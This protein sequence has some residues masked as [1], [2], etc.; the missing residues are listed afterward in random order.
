MSSSQT[1]T[2]Q[3]VTKGSSLQ[4]AD[5]ARISKQSLPKPPVFDDKYEEREYLKG[6]LAATFRLFAK[7]GFDDGV[8][9]HVTLRDPVDPDTFWVN[10]LGVPFA[11]L[12][13]SDLV[14]LDHDGVI[15][16]GGPVRVINKAAYLI[17]AAI[18]MERPDVN[19]AAHCHSIYART[20]CA[21][22][23]TLDMT[24]QDA[25]AFY[26][27]HS[28]Y[29]QYHG[30]VLSTEEGDRV[31]EALGN[32]KAVLMQHHGPLTVGRTIEETAFWYATLEKVCYSQLTIDT[33]AAGRGIPVKAISDEEAMDA[34]KTL[35]SPFIGWFAAQPMY[36]VIHKETN[37][38]YLS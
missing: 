35:G 1:T 14:Q 13:R 32:N 37:A 8:A 5:N 31:S 38:A 26:N 15:L 9:G 30:I 3:S 20:F 23:K 27:D 10:P 28:V 24:T 4:E 17:L 22:G 7:Y 6:R 12:K 19:C 33:I 2:L 21:F 34:Y 11:H 16:A 36:Q 29:E 18:H 25:C